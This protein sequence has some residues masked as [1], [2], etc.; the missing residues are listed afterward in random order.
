MTYKT[1][2]ELV[3]IKP[4]VLTVSEYTM[5]P[6]SYLVYVRVD[7]GGPLKTQ[8]TGGLHGYSGPCLVNSLVCIEGVWACASNFCETEEQATLESRKLRDSFISL[9]RDI[10]G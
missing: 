2:D 3:T 10:K 4:G 9:M 1:N 5:T 8:K 6:T 7:N